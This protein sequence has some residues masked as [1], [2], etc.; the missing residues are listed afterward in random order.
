M[1]TIGLSQKTR[2]ILFG[3]FLLLILIQTII[4]LS[5]EIEINKN[6]KPSTSVP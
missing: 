5:I 4:A 3:T 2:L 1:K 6:L